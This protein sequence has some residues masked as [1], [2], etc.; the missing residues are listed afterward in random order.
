MTSS[1]SRLG[2][3]PGLGQRRDQGDDEARIAQLARR[4]V[5]RDRDVA[6]ASS[7]PRWQAV[8]ST[9]S[10]IR[11]SMPVSSAIGMNLAG[12]IWPSSG[13]CQRSSASKLLISQRPRVDHRLVGEAEFAARRSRRAAP[14]RS[15]GAP[16]RGRGGRARRSGCRC[17]RRP[18]PGRARGR[19]CGSAPRP[20]RRR[21]GRS[22]RRCWRRRTAAA[23][24]RGTAPAAR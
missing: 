11:P 18:W 20:C 24:D 2:V 8:R 16:R 12:G 9:H 1:S 17:R 10:P 7:P 22:R 13:L 14:A 23:R 6:P 19:R 5:D 3:E 21:A 15:G 4:D